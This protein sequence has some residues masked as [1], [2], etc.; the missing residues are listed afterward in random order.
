MSTRYFSEN[1]ANIKRVNTLF[2]LNAT[3]IEDRDKENLKN[4]RLCEIKPVKYNEWKIV[5]VGLSFAATSASDLFNLQD[6]KFADQNYINLYS[7]NTMTISLL[8]IL[9]TFFSNKGKKFG[10]LLLKDKYFLTTL[11]NSLTT[12]LLFRLYD[13]NAVLLYSMYSIS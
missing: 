4:K 10:N 1:T 12:Q 6:K 2:D 7:H 9:S 13:K 11:L 8:W 3:K 5:R